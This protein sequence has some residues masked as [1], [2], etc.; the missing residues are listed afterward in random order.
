MNDGDIVDCPADECDERG[1]RKSIMA[2]Y[3]GKQDD[4][5]DGGY[6]RAKQLLEQSQ[7]SGQPSQEK[8]DPNVSEG[9]SNN[10]ED[11]GNP[12]T[13]G[14]SP[15]RQESSDD[16]G[17]CPDCDGELIDFTGTDEYQAENGY[18]YDV[19]ADYYCSVCGQGWNA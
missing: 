18:M 13:A 4:A 10:T 1:P 17:P 16:P 8:P 9:K 7:Q 11:D 19:P 15:R 12:L 14:P 5:H 2:H 6:Q 3:S